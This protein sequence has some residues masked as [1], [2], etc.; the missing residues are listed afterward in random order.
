MQKIIDQLDALLDRF[1]DQA[2]VGMRWH[3]PTRQD[4]IDLTKC[5][6]QI[7]EAIQKDAEEI[8]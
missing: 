4:F 7:A 3:T 1:D 2:P 5:V 6:K 8:D